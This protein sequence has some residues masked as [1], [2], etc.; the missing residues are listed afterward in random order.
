[1]WS[2]FLIIK[3]IKQQ[4]KME[5][6]DQSEMTQAGS[7]GKRC[8][9][10]FHNPKQNLNHNAKSC[11]L[12]HPNQAPEWGKEAQEKKSKIILDSSS[13]SH[14]LR[15]SELGRK[16]QISPS[17]AKVPLCFNGENSKFPLKNVFMF[18]R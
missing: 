7:A 18:L 17:E 14:I 4:E 10:G 13:S 6:K 3:P 9:N 16:T 1:M 15:S 2:L 11:W 12:L 5:I 8:R